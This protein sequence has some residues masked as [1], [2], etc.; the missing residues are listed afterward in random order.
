MDFQSNLSK[1]GLGVT[2]GISQQLYKTFDKQAEGL[3]EGESYLI[4]YDNVEVI[5]GIVTRNHKN[6]VVLQGHIAYKPTEEQIQQF[7]KDA[8]FF[9]FNLIESSISEK[10]L[11]KAIATNR[12]DDRDIREFELYG[13]SFALEMPEYLQ[14]M[15]D[16]MMLVEGA[17]D[18]SHLDKFLNALNLREL[19]DILTT[20]KDI[21]NK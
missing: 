20:I 21:S 1:F 9:H 18:A 15:K 17:S 2:L 19:A 6:V 13:F 3:D 16:Y 7:A 8:E 14:G 5:P 10:P 12:D 11:G 4:G